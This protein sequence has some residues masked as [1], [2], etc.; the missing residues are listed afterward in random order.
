[1]IAGYQQLFN[2][3]TPTVAAKK[4]LSLLKSKLT[5]EQMTANSILHPKPGTTVTAAMR[6]DAEEASKW[7]N[8]KFAPFLAKA[9]A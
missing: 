9:P 5:R 4:T 1:M 6:A 8:E 7:L 3:V 2:Q